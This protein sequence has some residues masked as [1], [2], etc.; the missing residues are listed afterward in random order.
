MASAEKLLFNI[1]E[2]LRIPDDRFLPLSFDETLEES[3]EKVCNDFELKS[4]DIANFKI[5]LAGLG[6][7]TEVVNQ[8]RGADKK[9]E[10]RNI[11]F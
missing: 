9:G 4:D 8:V 11:Q 3:V 7:I 2:R 5:A 1:I 10:F 6:A